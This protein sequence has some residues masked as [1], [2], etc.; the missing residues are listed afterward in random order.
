[1]VWFQAEGQRKSGERSGNP[2]QI[3]HHSMNLSHRLK[4][5]KMLRNISKMKQQQSV[6]HHSLY[7]AYQSLDRSGKEVENYVILPLTYGFS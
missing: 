3:P 1:M 2:F 7:M 6:A 4:S 5:A